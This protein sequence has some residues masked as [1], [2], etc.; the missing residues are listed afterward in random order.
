MRGIDLTMAEPEPEPIDDM[1]IL[2]SEESLS[3]KATA[4]LPAVRRAII[5]EKSQGTPTKLIAI[6]YDITAATVRRIVHD[7]FK[8]A[9]DVSRLIDEGA[10]KFK[11]RIRGKAA[12]AIESGL[13][14]E[15]DPYRQ[16]ALGVAVMRGI[17]EFKPDTAIEAKF[18][19]LVNAVPQEWKQRYIGSGTKPKQIANTSAE[20]EAEVKA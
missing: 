12:M 3:N 19:V 2:E 16:G 7:F 1:F 14:C 18:N 20:A 4:L 15:R 5:F 17:G 11:G 10:E 8:Q 13:D 9:A 6:K